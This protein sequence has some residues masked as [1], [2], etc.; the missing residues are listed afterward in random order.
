MRSWGMRSV[1]PYKRGGDTRVPSLFRVRVQQEG[2]HLQSQEECSPDPGAVTWDFPAW[3]PGSSK[4]PSLSL[5]S[6]LNLEACSA[7]KDGSQSLSCTDTVA[8]GRFPSRLAS[9]TLSGLPIRKWHVSKE[10]ICPTPSCWKFPSPLSQHPH[11][12]CLSL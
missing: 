7:W 2:G 6:S 9:I 8:S 5:P 12:S 3:S 10:G 11:T 4:C 1:P